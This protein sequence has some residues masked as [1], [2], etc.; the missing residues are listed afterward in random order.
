MSQGEE[1]S[2]LG[3]QEGAPFI[4]ARSTE[5]MPESNLDLDT[6]L[7]ENHRRFR[8]FLERRVEDSAAA[9]DILQSAYLKCM[10]LSDSIREEES[11]VAW[12][13]RVLR[14]A[15]TDYYRHRGAEYRAFTLAAGFVS[16][17]IDPE[18][19]VARSICQCVNDLLPTIKEDYAFLLRQIDLGDASIAE[20]AAELQ[21][22]P[23]NVR[24]RLHRARA[25][26]RKQLEFSCGACTEHGCLDCGCR[27][28]SNPTD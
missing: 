7:V 11:V 12:F 1:V 13:Y 10:E 5:T 26:L 20:I 6:V 21:L 22:T 19:D 9:E 17:V 28:S 2:P 25:A 14:N 23:N 4:M 27:R 24:V 16:E 18:A 8:A 3:S 15:V